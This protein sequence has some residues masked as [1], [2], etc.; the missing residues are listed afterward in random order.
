M[1]VFT[2]LLMA[3]GGV[4]TGDLLRSYV[5]PVVPQEQEQEQP[6]D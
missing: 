4:L 1:S 3:L 5:F 6:D 2:T